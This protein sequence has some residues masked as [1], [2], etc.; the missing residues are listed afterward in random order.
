MPHSSGLG[1]LCWGE[2]DK[3]ERGIRVVDGDCDIGSKMAGAAQQN[4]EW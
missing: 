4:A 2:E 3:D 1:R